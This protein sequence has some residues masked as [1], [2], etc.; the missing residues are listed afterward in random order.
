MQ[1]KAISVAFR[2]K[3]RRSGLALW[4]TQF[5]D[6]SEWV[7]IWEAECGLWTYKLWRLC[8]AD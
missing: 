8:L 3:L 1:W 6:L 7:T 5:G 2:L 4:V